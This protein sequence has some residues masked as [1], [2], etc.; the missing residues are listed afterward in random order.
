[1][2]AL[3]IIGAP[4]K[5]IFVFY[6]FAGLLVYFSYK[7]WRGG[8]DYLNFFRR[9]LARPAADFTPFVSIIAPCRGLDEDLETNLAALFRQD[10][11]RYE[12]L[13]VVDSET[14]AAVEIIKKLID[15]KDTKSTKDLKND[16]LCPSCL[17]GAKLVVAGKADNES[18]KVHNLREAVLHVDAESAVFVFVD[19]D[20]RPAAD[21]L[22]SLIAPLGDEKIGAA[23]AYR[24]FISKKI[25]FASELRSVW[26]AS[27]ASALG[28]N[29][30]GNFCWG[31]SMAIRR[32]TFEKL[33]L[34]EKWRGTLSDDFA[35]TR[36]MHEARLPIC[37]VPQALAVS[38]ENCGLTECLEFT[39]RQMKITRVYAPHL[40]K[41]SFMGAGLFN[42][43]WLWGLF[44]LFFY[45]PQ[46]AAFRLS[47]AALILVSIFSIGKSRL[48]L[49]A[50]KL[51]LKDYERELGRQFWTQ[52]TLW[53]FSP[54]L[55]FYNS[56]CALLSREIRWRGIRYRLASP[57]QTEIL[58]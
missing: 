39:T 55:F 49:K 11:P 20:A 14:D 35:V 18:Q 33:A 40:W 54:P 29:M 31:G 15:R 13:F 10:F 4:I 5:M 9:E 8:I 56:L 50:V 46:S 41:M 48:R 2:P 58:K 23:T 27:I 43:V 42:L 16:P 38:V 52:N 12:V 1:M 51:V 7:S 24:W 21:W 44:N 30:K 32:E 6:I 37:F 3:Q 34:R 53:V 45:A 25:S 26:N 28:A 57:T 19:S 36:A 22:R 47:L 17:C